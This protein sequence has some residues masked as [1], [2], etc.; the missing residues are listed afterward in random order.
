MSKEILSGQNYL[1]ADKTQGPMFI[2]VFSFMTACS[3]VEIHRQYFYA[4]LPQCK[5][6]YYG[7]EKASGS[8]M[9]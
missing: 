4:S 5:A 8:L 2:A 9:F 6:S 7:R 3:L 1:T